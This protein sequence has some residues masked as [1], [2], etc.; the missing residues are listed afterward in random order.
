MFSDPPMKK[1][2]DFTVDD[3]RQVF[4]INLLAHFITCKVSVNDC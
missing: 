3:F 2:D 1:I 4:D